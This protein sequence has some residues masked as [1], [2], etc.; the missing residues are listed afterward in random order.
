MGK[1]SNIFGPSGETKRLIHQGQ[2]RHTATPP[3]LREG[4]LV[5]A[6]LSKGK[7]SI[8]KRQV[9]YATTFLLE[10]PAMVTTA[11]PPSVTTYKFAMCANKA[12]LSTEL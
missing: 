7:F 9:H 8:I 1:E 6:P 3:T 11:E 4:K 2:L 5:T 12:A 10:I